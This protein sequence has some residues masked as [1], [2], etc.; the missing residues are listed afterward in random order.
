MENFS[1]DSLLEIFKINI[2]DIDHD[3][4]N[5]SPFEKM[6]HCF[7]NELDTSIHDLIEIIVGK[8]S[9]EIYKLILYAE[10][11]S[12]TLWFADYKY[13]LSESFFPVLSSL[14]AL[15]LH[16]KINII[17]YCD[18][19][20]L[21]FIQKGSKI[22]KIISENDDSDTIIILL[23][24]GNLVHLVQSVN[25]EMTLNAFAEY[26]N[27]NSI[28]N[29]TDVIINFSSAKDEF[30]ISKKRGRSDMEQIEN[31]TNQDENQNI[32]QSR[33]VKYFKNIF[34]IEIFEY[35]KTLN[36][37]G[38]QSD[39]KNEN[40]VN[41]ETISRTIDEF[42]DLYLQNDTEGSHIEDE[43]YTN[44]TKI[45]FFESDYRYKWETDV[46][47]MKAIDLDGFFGVFDD[48]QLKNCLNS[49]GSIV[50]FK[51]AAEYKKDRKTI[52]KL[53]KDSGKI[54]N[55]S[56]KAFKIAE[57]DTTSRFELIVVA[58]FEDE[59]N[60]SEFDFKIFLKNAHAHANRLPCD[61]FCPFRKEHR[62]CRTGRPDYVDQIKSHGY[63]WDYDKIN[64]KCMI[65]HFTNYLKTL[66]LAI[67]GLKFHYVVRNIGSKFKFHTVNLDN[68]HGLI[69]DY[70]SPFK[71]HSLLSEGGPKIFLDI[72]WRFLHFDHSS[73][74][75]VIIKCFLRI[76][77]FFSY[78]RYGK[79]DPCHKY[80][81]KIHNY[82]QCFSHMIAQIFLEMNGKVIFISLIFTM[83]L[84]I[85]CS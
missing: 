63:K 11:S 55:N 45:N 73:D 30:I 56:L 72:S 3:E 1:T 31:E 67:D 46:D 9:D 52:E 27:E 85:V 4:E 17:I 35:I 28:I 13:E 50:P 6:L 54:F 69:T 41:A 5:I 23:S 48:F 53:L 26:I 34:D 51:D 8:K 29:L 32:E 25:M 16:F 18:N 15:S 59:N 80:F 64:F 83:D 38:N 66:A 47:Q 21:S 77:K 61:E 42:V 44:N 10:Y 81:E 71:I 2:A 14:I 39:R 40:Y 43:A 76:G 57:L 79:E 20:S 19:F 84:L 49:G 12:Q 68:I 22:I 74:I 58:I 60:F 24:K 65:K 82:I 70:L 37:R 78:V 62:I 75:K 33:C 36:T 7:S